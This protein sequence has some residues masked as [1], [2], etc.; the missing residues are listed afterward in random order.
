MKLH[1]INPLRLLVTIISLTLLINT[2]LAAVS[3]SG[4]Q[5]DVGM[6]HPVKRVNYN[7]IS[8]TYDT[9]LASDVTA[10]VIPEDKG[11]TDEPCWSTH[12]DEV[13]FKFHNFAFATE[14]MMAATIYVVPINSDYQ[15]TN[16]LETID[17]WGREMV[18]LQDILAR[19]PSLEEP[20]TAQRSTLTPFLPPINAAGHLVGKHEYLNFRN[21]SGMRYL[22]QFTQ[23]P[24][25]PNLA[26]TIYT[27]QE[28]TDDGKYYIAAT[29]PAFL[30]TPLDNPMEQFAT[31]Q[32]WDNFYHQLRVTVNQ[33]PNKDF[34]PNLDTLDGIFSSLT[35][36]P[37]ANILPSGPV[38]SNLP[39]TGITTNK[40]L[41]PPG[42]SIAPAFVLALVL[43]ATGLVFRNKQH[44]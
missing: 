18:A 12:P 14:R 32:G 21:G 10:S 11:G 4:S 25:K 23:Q 34:L 37:S 36:N 6:A 40:V 24:I 42:E 15:C 1:L 35:V 44:S 29:L 31:Q 16:P 26:D 2:S 39:Q 9:S 30:P 33:I 43:I 17:F 20:A 7:G 13:V 38:A 27:Y 19:R 41:I 8:F 5:G 28:I 3:A 22:I